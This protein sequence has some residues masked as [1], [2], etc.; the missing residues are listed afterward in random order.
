MYYNNN[1]KKQHALPR[2]I[3]VIG[4]ASGWGAQLRATEK[5]PEALQNLGCMSELT[6]LGLDIDWDGLILPQVSSSRVNIPN[7]KPTLPYVLDHC[8]RLAHVV[9]DVIEQQQFPVVIG[10]D[11]AI[12]MGTWTGVT[13]A[14]Q[15]H[16]KFGLL[17][18]DAHMDANTPETSPS[19]AYHGMPLAC[20]LGY[21]EPEL[22]NLGGR[23]P[24]ISPNNVVLMGIRS[25][26]EGEKQLLEHLGVRI[27]Y[28]QEIQQ[29]G[30]EVC[31]AEALEILNK[32]T[33]GFGVTIDLDAFDP[34]EAPG[35]GSPEPGGLQADFVCQAFQ[36]LLARHPGFTA[37]EIT[38]YN[39]EQDQDHITGRLACRLIK[40]LLST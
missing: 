39:P 25:F 18:I 36:N 22:V 19:Q 24:K 40:E 15:A 11:H 16:E 12:A 14:L 38:E 26:E 31:L 34:L 13:S 8:Q 9:Q 32:G 37:L 7:G 33:V 2:A 20:L 28:I 3:R 30:F 35:V 27:F 6:R 10:G 29:R 21:G 1:N 17:W 4:A 23:A 5:G